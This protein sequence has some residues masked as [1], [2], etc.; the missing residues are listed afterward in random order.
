[1][2][3]SLY[4]LLYLLALPFALLRQHLRGGRE[5]AWR[6]DRLGRFGRLRDL[7]RGALWIHAVSAGETI[8]AVPLVKALRVRHPGVPILFTVTTASGRDRA[9]RLLGDSVHL[10]WL[11]WDLPWTQRRFIRTAAPRLLVI[12]ETELWPNL[13]AE[14]R[15]ARVPVLLANARLS[16]RSAKGYARVAD[17]T[18]DMLA[19]LDGIACQDEAT[20]VRF[21]ALGAQRE[22]IEITGSI[23]FDPHL[24]EDLDRRIGQALDR[25]GVGAARIIVAASTHDDEEVRLIEG[26]RAMLEANPGWRLV[27]VPR[28][29][30]R[31]DNVWALCRVSGLPAARWSDGPAS[32]GTRLVLADVM[33]ELLAIYGIAD[34][35][36]VGGSLVARGGHNPIEPALHGVPIFTGPHLYNFET[37]AGEFVASGALEVVPDAVTLAARVTLL[38]GDEAERRRRGEAG[39]AVVRA[40]RG[41]LERVADWVSARVPEPPSDA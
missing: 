12:L 29:P 9:R 18:R 21:E 34:V 13:L 33:G 38:L 23:K 40:G 20:A 3:L 36:F 14:C 32:A 26:L 11:P 30:E 1:M 7:P 27:I 41:S 31:F 22:R 15:R 6:E 35:V 2:W 10:R 8:A 28:H 39:R 25:C 24:P 4:T 5:A 16:L 17:L 37:I 19:G